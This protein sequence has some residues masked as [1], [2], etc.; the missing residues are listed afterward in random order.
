[1]KSEKTIEK[2]DLKE[3]KKCHY[4]TGEFYKMICNEINDCLKCEHFR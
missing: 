3:T 1:M 2:E 4:Y